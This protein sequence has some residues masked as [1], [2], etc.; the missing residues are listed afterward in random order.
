MVYGTLFPGYLKYEFFDGK[1]VTSTII[2]RRTGLC[3]YEQC[4]Q[5]MIRM[6]QTRDAA[7]PDE[8]WFL[9]HPPV[10][11]QGQAGRA[12]HILNSGAIPVMQ[13]DRGGQVTYHGP[14]QLVCYLLLDLKRQGISI[15]A[16]VSHM[17]QALIDML[18]ELGI[19]AE[20]MPGA[21]GVYVG[22]SKIA[23]LGVRVR[24]GCCYHGLALNVCMDTEPFRR[25][26]PCGYPG[27]G[28]TQ[29]RDQGIAMNTS[30]AA[31]AL[32]PHLL[33]RLGYD[34]YNVVHACIPDQPRTVPLAS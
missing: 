1:T 24:N 5:A 26:N 27:L 18:G 31:D 28:V 7:T 30:Q 13:S 15:K 2:I 11:T 14:G 8:I 33:H 34:G 6:N 12:E 4:Y 29:L 19:T 22:A 17:E 23:A 16:L 25:I 9:E 32:L 20:R 10:F 21:P 3:D